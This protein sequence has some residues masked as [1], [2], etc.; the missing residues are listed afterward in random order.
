MSKS[1]A[2]SDPEKVLPPGKISMQAPGATLGSVDTVMP[3]SSLRKLP[4]RKMLYVCEVGLETVIKIPLSAAVKSDTLTGYGGAI[5][6][7]DVSLATAMRE[8]RAHGQGRRYYHTRIGVG[9]RMDTLHCAVVLAK[10]ERFDWEVGQR[11]ELGTRYSRLLGDYGVVTPVIAADRTSVYAQYTIRAPQRD[12]LCE[13]LR[14]LGIPTAVH[15]PLPIHRQPAY[16][17]FHD[18]SNLPEADRAAA[19]VISLPMYPDMDVTTQDR[20]VSAVRQALEQIKNQ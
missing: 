3:L 13:V 1:S 11:G 15:Y 19:E 16:A 7:S 8:I 2:N 14:R 17:G 6:T 5:F 18:G 4:D 20:I 9:G 10:M 12:A